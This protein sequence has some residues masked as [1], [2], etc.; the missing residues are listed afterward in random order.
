MAEPARQAGP[1]G[2]LEQEALKLQAT[3]VG[4][5]SYTVY[6]YLI[7]QLYTLGS[8]TRI[9]DNCKAPTT[10]LTCDD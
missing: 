8:S 2:D 1:E 3:P 7:P 6:F 9:I 5:W 10:T 4:I